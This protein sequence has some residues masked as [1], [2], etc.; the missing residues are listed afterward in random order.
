MII[1]VVR[2]VVL[3]L[4]GEY[5]TQLLVDGLDALDLGVHV[6]TLGAF[7]LAVILV[8]ELSGGLCFLI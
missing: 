8:H 4:L 1:Q 3:I 2:L 6:D 5:G 7:N